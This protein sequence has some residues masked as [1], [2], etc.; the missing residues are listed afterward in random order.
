MSFVLDT[1]T[2]DNFQTKIRDL[3]IGKYLED[4]SNFYKNSFP[5]LVNFYSGNID[6]INISIFQNLKNLIDRSIE[7]SNEVKLH[8]FKF[9]NYR[10][11]E[12]IDYLED[13]KANLIVMTKTSKFLRSSRTNSSYNS[14]VEFNHTLETYETLEEVSGKIKDS[15]NFDNDWVDIAIRNNLSELDYTIQG[16]NLLILSIDKKF[17]RVE[18]TAVVDNI[19]GERALGIDFN[20]KITFDN[21]DLL[22]LSYKNT[23]VQSVKILSSI[24]RGDIP[25]FRSIGITGFVGGTVNSIALS[26]IIRQLNEVFST[27]DTL[28]NFKIT[29]LKIVGDSIFQTF[30]VNTRTDL[31]INETIKI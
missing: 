20:R 11:F 3:N 13:I 26:S 1:D 24:R 30:E 5:I 27:D 23:A 21:D 25:E 16:G 12:M 15:Q 28:D 4:Y 2:L 22:V 10:D 18:I 17:K 29:N 7:I 14:S 9:N 19:F 8:N 6:K 31:I